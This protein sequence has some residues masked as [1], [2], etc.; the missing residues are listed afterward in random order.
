MKKKQFAGY[1]AS[2]SNSGKR[3]L[4]QEKIEV[5]MLLFVKYLWI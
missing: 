1:S 3:E 5:G 4:A 2:K